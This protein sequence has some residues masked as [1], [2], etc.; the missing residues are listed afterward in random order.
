MQACSVQDSEGNLSGKK[1][2]VEKKRGGGGGE[3]E[4]MR[5]VDSKIILVVQ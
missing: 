5:I 1:A 3:G 4:G 2:S